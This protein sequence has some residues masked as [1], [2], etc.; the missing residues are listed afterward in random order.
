MPARMRSSVHA[1]GAYWGTP[2]RSTGDARQLIQGGLL[3]QDMLRGDARQL[4]L[5]GLLTQDMLRGDARQLI[6]RRLTDTRHVKGRRSAT[7]GADW[8]TPTRLTGRRSTTHMW[9][10]L[11]MLGRSA[12]SCGDK[13]SE[14]A[15]QYARHSMLRMKGGGSEG[16]A[17]GLCAESVTRGAARREAA[18]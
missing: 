13:C 4:I 2:T 1:T 10:D 5:G 8:G 12:M 17:S 15:R 16:E 3:T 6:T 11:Q 18:K 14:H 9:S 7:T